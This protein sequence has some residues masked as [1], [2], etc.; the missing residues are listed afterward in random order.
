MDSHA[1]I[2]HIMASIIPEMGKISQARD[3]K[4]YLVDY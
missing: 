1:I 4:V 2:P 3:E